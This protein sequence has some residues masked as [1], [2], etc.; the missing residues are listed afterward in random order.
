MASG[1]TPYQALESGTRNVAIFFKTVDETGTVSAG[2][3][4]DPI[5]LDADPLMDISN[6]S[7]LS[8]VM[9][10]GRWLPKEELQRR[11]QTGS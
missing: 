11:L 7:K 5:L 3:R 6:S 1:L 9:L 2:R 10:R 4:A 8:G